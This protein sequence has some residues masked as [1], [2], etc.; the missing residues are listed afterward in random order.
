M[1]IFRILIIVSAIG[2]AS[3]TKT[4][5]KN[6]PRYDSEIKE[7]LAGRWKI[8]EL[9]SVHE[10]GEMPALVSNYKGTV[11]DY[12]EF[13]SEGNVYVRI[14][15]KTDQLSYQVRDGKV[16]LSFHEFYTDIMTV[17]ALDKNNLSLRFAM[18]SEL[19]EGLTKKAVF[20][21]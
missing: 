14:G 4:A 15:D 6:D 17:D 1:Q 18:K 5:Q 9:S 8:V 2:L 7:M 10:T 13:D 21:R 16:H 19:K 3:C 20:T 11:S 12:Y